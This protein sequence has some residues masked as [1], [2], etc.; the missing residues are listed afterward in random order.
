MSRRGE[1]SPSRI[2]VTPPAPL[3]RAG[4]GSEQPALRG[5]GTWQWWVGW[6]LPCGHRLCQGHICGCLLAAWAASS[7]TGVKARKPSFCSL[8]L[9]LVSLGAGCS[10][11]GWT[12]MCSPQHPAEGNAQAQ[13][14]FSVSVVLPI[15]QIFKLPLVCFQ[16]DNADMETPYIISQ[17][18]DS[19]LPSCGVSAMQSW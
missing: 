12:E 10:V 18:P 5:G 2:Q 7:A 15:P 19:K 14:C 6:W 9:M 3:A 4:S 11:W 13:L 8:A 16:F 17:P 1:I